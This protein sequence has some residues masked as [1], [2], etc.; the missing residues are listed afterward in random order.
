M[1][2]DAIF[3]LIFHRKRVFFQIFNFYLTPRDSL[4]CVAQ[5]DSNFYER[6]NERTIKTRAQLNSEAQI[7]MILYH[8]SV[9]SLSRF[10]LLVARNLDIDLEV[11]FD[12]FME[13]KS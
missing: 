5:A 13:I 3:F 6:Q 7:E 10:A 9:S 11:N 4:K 12:L 8:F 1:P 2:D